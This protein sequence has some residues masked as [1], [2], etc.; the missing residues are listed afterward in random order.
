MPASPR[1][2]AIICRAACLMVCLCF[3]FLPSARAQQSR[4]LRGTVEDSTGLPI[5]GA[6]VEF[7]AGSESHSVATGDTGA[8]EISATVGGVLIVRQPGFAPATIPV[9]A[10]SPADMLEVRLN[11][12]PDTQRIVVSAA[13]DGDDRIAPVPSSKFL[14]PR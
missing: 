14:I 8:F 2:F 4:T 10:S 5:R 7:Q 1:S 3:F 9:E 11:P 6:E 13:A 12:A